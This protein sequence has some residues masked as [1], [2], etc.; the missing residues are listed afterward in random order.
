MRECS[1][2]KIGE[3]AQ[4]GQV[5]IATLRHYDQYGL[6]KPSALD[7]NTGYRYYSLDQLPRLHRIVAFKDLGFPLELIAQLLEENL[8][9]EQ[10]QGM[11]RLKQAQIQQM[12]DM[13]QARLAR[14]AA[15]LRQIEQEG[16]M[17]AYDVRLKQIDP[18]LAATVREI[19]S[20]DD[21]LGQQYERISTYL[22]QQG[23]QHTQPHLLLRY[24]R[25]ELHDDGMYADV[26]LAVP[27]HA[28][29][30][31]N[32]LVSVRTLP[33]GLM[34][35][36]VHTGDTLSLGQAYVALHRWMEDNRY[37]IIGPP[38]QVHLQ[39]AEHMDPSHSVTE[40]QFPV[41]KQD[42]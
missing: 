16:S 42:V 36:T 18:L 7:P 11:F 34:A 4:I 22:D 40:L 21:D 12:I 32:E 31:G 28:S 13:E 38:R 19:V 6:L 35:C 5:S 23:V 29:L 27:L 30:P 26:E 24:S 39:S 41:A 20:I 3:F 10:L 25:Y 37:R 14:V 15:R 1:M 33:G 8:S 9:L 17:P 2:L